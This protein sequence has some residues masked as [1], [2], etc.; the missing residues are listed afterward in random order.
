[1]FWDHCSSLV[2]KVREIFS[3][4]FDNGAVDRINFDPDMVQGLQDCKCLN[5]EFSY[6][7]DFFCWKWN[8]TDLFPSFTTKP[9]LL[10][11]TRWGLFTISITFSLCW[12]TYFTFNWMQTS[13]AGVS[14][15]VFVLLSWNF[16]RLFYFISGINAPVDK[17]ERLKIASFLSK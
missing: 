12:T 6:K 14:Y 9:L 11:M 13:S 2:T 5:A 15:R 8:L 16:S 10:D 17:M 4:Y 7:K 3:S 1:M